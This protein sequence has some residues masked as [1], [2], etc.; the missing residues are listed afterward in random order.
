[1]MFGSRYFCA[2]YI[3]RFFRGID[4]RHQNNRTLRCALSIFH[5][6]FFS[7]FKCKIENIFSL[8]F[9]KICFCLVRASDHVILS[10]VRVNV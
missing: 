5:C 9:S 2:I 8:K 4:E 6:F 3:Y 10:H 7:F 1:M